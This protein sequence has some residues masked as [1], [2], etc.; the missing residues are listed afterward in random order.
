MDM[1][2]L[3]LLHV[4]KLVVAVVVI[5]CVWS[6]YGTMTNEET[7]TTADEAEIKKIFNDLQ[8]AQANPGR[9]NFHKV[10]DFK[11]ELLG[12]LDNLQVSSEPPFRT[13]GSTRILGLV[14][15]SSSLVSPMC[16]N[17]VCPKLKLLTALVYLICP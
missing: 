12:R 9:P 16:T 2:R 1:K 7:I 4:E 10:R 6:V 17:W 5:Y 3:L 14:S 11:A 13:C 15:Q 8:N